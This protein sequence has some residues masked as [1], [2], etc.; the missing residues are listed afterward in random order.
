MTSSLPLSGYKVLDLTQARAGP[1][2]VRLLTDWGAT[3]YRIV[4]PPSAA[5]MENDHSGQN[6]PDTQNL[7]RNK[8]GISLDLKS[9][10]G[11]EL[12]MTLVESS[13][14]IVE[15][16]RADVKHRLGVDYEAVTKV[17]PNIIYASISGFGQ[18]GPYSDRPGVD[19][20]T[21]GTSGLM[22]VTGEP[23]RGPVR[24]G[25][26]I[27]DT[28]AGMFLGQGILLAL[29]H[30]ER[31]GEGQWV[32]T[33]LL[34]A[35]LCKLDFQGSRY[36]MDGDVAEQQGNFHPTNVPMGLYD[37]AD[38]PVNISASGERMLRSFCNALDATH[39]LDDP[40]F[41]D[42][43]TRVEH[44][45]EVNAEVNA[46]T[47]RFTVAEL[48]E[49]LNPVGVPCGPVY[50]IGEAFDDPQAQHLNMVWP[51][52]HPVRGSINLVRTPINMSRC[53]HAGE[54]HH[55]EPAPGEHTEE[56]LAEFGFTAEQVK[57][58]SEQGVVHTKVQP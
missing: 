40:R 56:I 1:T 3:V 57:E 38:G 13:D 41:V 24:V 8:R 58:L 47:A 43:P 29:L 33:S 12:F 17:N 6:D 45:A 42:E 55:C 23:G 14:V 31:T 35:M 28:S 30:R 26:A 51:A 7:H 39:L 18:S 48:V 44:R 52:P 22:S 53:P 4:P 19:Q 21:Q 10:R 37:A 20:I 11:L 15:N 25:I 34:E 46:I 49:K 5:L 36:T 2:A 27:S 32:H 54:F 9:S 50:S 16:F